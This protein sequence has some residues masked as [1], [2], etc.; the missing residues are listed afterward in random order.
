MLRTSGRRCLSAAAARARKVTLGGPPLPP[1]PLGAMLGHGFPTFEVF[2]DLSCPF[3]VTAFNTLHDDVEPANRGRASFVVHNVVQPWHAHSTVMHE[4]ALAVLQEAPAG[5]FAFYRQACGAF[6]DFA[7]AAVRGETRLQTG[8]RL[9]AIAERSTGLP[10][11]AINALLDKHAMAQ[12]LKWTCR[13]HRARGVHVT[14]TV[15]LH[16]LEATAIS[17]SW[18]AAEW[19]A[20]LAEVRAAQ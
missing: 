13:H 18:T 7:E 11:A 1:R 4:V 9:A 19:N 3:S 10:A 8:A 6:D 2:L 5:Y 14:P 17:S 16:G 12:A 15:F 20:L